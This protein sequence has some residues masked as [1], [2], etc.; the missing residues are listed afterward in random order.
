MAI[1][2]VSFHRPRTDA[3][4]KQTANAHSD[5]RC[6]DRPHF[7]KKKGYDV[8]ARNPIIGIS[9]MKYEDCPKSMEKESTKNIVIHKVTLSFIMPW[10][11]AGKDE[12]PPQT[13]T[14]N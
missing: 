8:R 4:T 3:H 13:A 12:G 5:T 1:K 14:V 6:S 9:R 7:R 10:E 11:I 2:G